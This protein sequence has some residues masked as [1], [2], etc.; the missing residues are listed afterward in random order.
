MTNPNLEIRVDAGMRHTNTS[1]CTRGTE[2]DAPQLTPREADFQ[3]GTQDSK[4]AL[5]GPETPHAREGP[6]LGA[7]RLWAALG[8]PD[9]P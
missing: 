2:G 1:M 9:H 5:L 7:R 3:R 4:P 8:R 6:R